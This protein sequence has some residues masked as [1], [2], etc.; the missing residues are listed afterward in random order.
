VPEQLPIFPLNTVVFPGVT[1]PLHVFEKRYRAMVRHLLAEPDPTHRLFGI[2]AIR[3]GYEVGSHESRAMYRTGC[4][5][6]LTGV[7]RYDD[8]TYDIE[9]VG[10]HRMRV[11]GIDASGPFVVA[12][13]A[14]LPD[15]DT[16]AVTEDLVLDEAGR[17]LGAF[18][19]YRKLL[20][21]IRGGDVLIGK[22]PRD[23]ELLSYSLA[24]T[25]LLSLRERQSLL[26]AP[27][28]H[29]RLVMLRHTLRE[30]IRAMH[31]VPSLP[32]TEVARTSW[33]PN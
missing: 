12:E 17:T 3:E 30:E 27:T 28:T 1:M 10:R 2:V 4:V 15:E 25:A 5:V 7:E 32:A 22:M 23:P 33:S 16:E 31:A 24:A 9:V 11:N 14:D 13:M 21:E 20:S 18:E 29:E 19:D 8:G 6:Q 26:E